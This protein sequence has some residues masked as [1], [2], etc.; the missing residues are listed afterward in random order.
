MEVPVLTI[1]G[2][3]TGRKVELKKSI[4]EIKPNDHAIY[5]D[6][7]QY[8]AGNRQGTHQ[9]KARGE[10][11]GSTRKIKRQKGTG[12]ARAGSVKSPVRRGG[13]RAFGPISKDYD[14]KVN[15]KVKRLARLSALTYKA[16][17]NSVIVLEDFKLDTPKTKSFVDLRRNLNIGSKRSL[18]VLNIPDENIYLSS[19]N[20]QDSKIIPVAELNTYDIMHAAVVVFMES[21]LKSL[22]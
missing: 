5:L 19:R 13:G 12:T 4:F 7:K 6:V 1:T 3:D 21:S 10:V 9:A 15:K 8:M 17:E 16:K 20:L 14:M 22:Q 2:E 18:M 11:A